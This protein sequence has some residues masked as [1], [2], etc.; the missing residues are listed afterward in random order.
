MK[1]TFDCFWR[2]NKKNTKISSHHQH[3]GVLTTVFSAN[4]FNFPRYVKV[5]IS[6]I[7]YRKNSIRQ[8]LYLG[9]LQWGDRR[10]ATGI[11]KL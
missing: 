6:I 11:E 5:A 8:K 3:C 2:F 1:I 10:L 9:E 7:Y 4:V